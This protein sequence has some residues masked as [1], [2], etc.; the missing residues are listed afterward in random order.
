MCLLA[1]GPLPG[2]SL[3]FYTNI[4][5]T[6]TY[7]YIIGHQQRKLIEEC[8]IVINHKMVI[9]EK[10]ILVVVLI[11]AEKV[12]T[13][14]L[15]WAPMSHE[16]EVLKVKYWDQSMSVLCVVKNFLYHWANFN[17]PHKTEP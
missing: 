17:Q 9:E 11:K 15:F 10:D 3:Q 14:G 5:F 1:Q 13:E 16:H 8:Q 4:L 6:K 2:I 7:V 12:G